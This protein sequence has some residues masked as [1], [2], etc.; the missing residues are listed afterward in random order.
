MGGVKIVSLPSRSIV[1]GERSPGTIIL[2]DGKHAGCG[3]ERT[4]TSH[5]RDSEKASWRR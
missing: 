1:Y 5:G 2:K 3:V 4:V